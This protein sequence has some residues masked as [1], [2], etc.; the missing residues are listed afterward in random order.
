MFHSTTEN[1]VIKMTWSA[2][3][4]QKGSFQASIHFGG[5]KLLEHV[6]VTNAID[7]VLC[8]E[9]MSN[10]LTDEYSAQMSTLGLSIIRSRVQKFQAWPTV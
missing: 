1:V 6:Q 9:G 3:L 10:S 4:F 5:C 7:R 2:V 8:E